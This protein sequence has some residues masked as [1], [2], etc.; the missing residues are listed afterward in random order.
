MDFFPE[1]QKQDNVLAIFDKLPF[2]FQSKQL[3]VGQEAF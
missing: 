2:V 1:K 3:F